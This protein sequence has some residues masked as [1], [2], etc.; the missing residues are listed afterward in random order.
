HPRTDR[1]PSH[2]RMDLGGRGRRHRRPAA[3]RHLHV[4]I[5]GGQLHVRPGAAAGDPA[6]LRIDPGARRALARG[7]AHGLRRAQP[8]N[9]RRARLLRP[10]VRPSGA[11]PDGRRLLSPADHRLVP[12][13]REAARMSAGM[14]RFD[15]AGWNAAVDALASGKRQLVALWGEPGTVHLAT[16]DKATIHSVELVCLAGVFP[17]VGRVHPAAI[18][19]ERAITDLYGLA[20]YGAHDR[21]PWLDHGRWAMRHPLG[22][23]GEAAKAS[24]YA[25]LPAEGEGLH[26]I[27]VGPVHAGV[28]EPGHFRFTASGETIVRL[29][30][31]LGYVHRGLLARMEGAALA[32]AARLAGRA[33]GDST[34]A[35]AI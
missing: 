19:P 10:H 2:P 26:Q 16:A 22:P 14:A 32:D 24:S 23:K 15:P 34:V 11:G 31:R 13:R 1:H 9:R 17:S 7:P 35:Y 12:A 18:R 21:R 20:P 8:R 27:P 28:I 3:L 30:A 6:R 5:P 25:F 33:S 4:R 29:E